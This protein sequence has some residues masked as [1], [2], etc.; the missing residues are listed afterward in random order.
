MWLHFILVTLKGQ[1]QS[2]SDFESLYML[3]T[4]YVIN[5]AKLGHMLLVNSNR[6]P[7]SGCDGQMVSV[8]DS[9][10]QDCGFESR[11]SQ[12]A[13]QKPSR[14]GYGWWQ[15]CLGSLSRKWLP[16]ERQRWQ[17]YL[18]DYPWRLEV[19]KW[20]YAPQ[21]VTFYLS[22]PESSIQGHSDFEGLYLEKELT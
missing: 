19:C 9:Q 12:S 5:F 16:A 1:C 15:W 20:V 10:P 11:Q 22:G 17:L 14:V 3:Y 6:K 21:G 7:L 13:H 18:L 8:S 4:L 2:Q